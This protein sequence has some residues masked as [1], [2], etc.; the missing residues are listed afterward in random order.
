MMRLLA[1]LALGSDLLGRGNMYHVC[2]FITA[3]HIPVGQRSMQELDQ[4][5]NG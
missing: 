2:L 1:F 4:L 3:A 5:E